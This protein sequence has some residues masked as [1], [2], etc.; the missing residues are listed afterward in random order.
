MAETSQR[1][2]IAFVKRGAFSHINESLR[3]ALA[4]EL[5]GYDV[6]VVEILEL[7]ESE[8]LVAKALRRVY[9]VKEFWRMLLPRPG[10][11]RMAGCVIRTSFYLRRLR[12]LLSERLAE[13]TYIFTLQTQSLFDASKPGTPHF[14]YTDHAALASESWPRFR[15]AESYPRRW[16]ELEA[17]IYSNAAGVFTMSE[18]VRRC[19]ID[20]YGLPESRVARVGAGANSAPPPAMEQ[21]RDRYAAGRVVFVGRHWERKGGP[22]LVAAF[23]RVR[24]KHPSATL[25]I[26]GCSP[27][28]RGPGYQVV[29]LVPLEEM[30]RHYARASVFCL[31]SRREAFGI[32]V[33]EA[34]ARGLP[35]VVTRVGAFP[36]LVADGQTG[37]VVEQGDVDALAQR[38]CDLIADPERSRQFGEAAR[39]DVAERYSWERTATQIR[40]RV[41]EVVGPL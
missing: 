25:T 34:L 11:A 37:Y 18:H 6:D 23:E 35:A 14:V 19:L 28:M 15:P 4:R 9:A 24:R 33:L 22:E 8:P 5:H 2:A 26:V 36:E 16:I 27:D 31:P 12:A 41:E 29:G 10:R 1:P 30:E 38:L 32:A 40:A 39:R 21:S 7:T 17:S 20:D 13:R 3:Q